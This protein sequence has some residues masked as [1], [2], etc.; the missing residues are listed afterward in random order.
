M[1]KQ[2]QVVAGCDS[3]EQVGLRQSSKVGIST[4]KVWT[5]RAG[6]SGLCVRESVL[7]RGFYVRMLIS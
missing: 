3:G 2:D 6:G 7:S 5:L 4:P 1:S